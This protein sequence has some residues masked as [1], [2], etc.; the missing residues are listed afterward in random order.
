MTVD[1]RDLKDR[2]IAEGWQC[3][4]VNRAD[5]SDQIH[6]LAWHLG[7]PL[8]GRK[9][10]LV[11]Q[12]TPTRCESAELRSLSAIHGQ[13]SFPLHTDGAH[14][15]EPPRFL[16]LACTELGS[17]PMPTVM[18]R[19]KDLKIDDQ[20]KARCAAGVFLIKNGRRSFYS[21][22]Y[23]PSR[24]FIRFDQGCMFPA[25]E[26]AQHV[27]QLISK[28]LGEVRS[29]IHWQKGLVVIIDNWCVLHGR[30]LGHSI[31]ST[32]RQLLRVSIQ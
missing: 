26:E 6:K 7:R 32:D 19:F 29:A 1:M 30:G 10:G 3:L 5:L 16:I 17:A 13:T 31:A 14:L 20:E 28:R 2:V 12:L 18:A 21:S 9:G 22:V 24:L 8:R 25:N 11:E 15:L 23:D 27:T 4:S